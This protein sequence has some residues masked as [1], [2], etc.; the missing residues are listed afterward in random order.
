VV[1]HAATADDPSAFFLAHNKQPLH[2][3]INARIRMVSRLDKKIEQCAGV[4]GCILICQDA[5]KVAFIRLARKNKFGRLLNGGVCAIHF[6]LSDEKTQLPPCVGSFG[7]P[8]GSGSALD[9]LPETVGP[10]LPLDFPNLRKVPHN[11]NGSGV[12]IQQIPLCDIIDR[13]ISECRQ[14]TNR[15]IFKW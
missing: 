14:R 3:L 1:N 11:L 8:P 5:A 2:P 13:S 4:L 10:L 6:V 12:S 15:I 7:L 9:G